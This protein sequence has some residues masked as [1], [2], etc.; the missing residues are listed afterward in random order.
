[1]DISNKW[2]TRERPS[3][4][5]FR[6]TGSCHCGPEAK[7]R[8][9]PFHRDGTSVLGSYQRANQVLGTVSTGV[10]TKP[11]DTM[12][13]PESWMQMQF[14]SPDLKGNLKIQTQRRT[15]S[16]NV[17]TRVFLAQFWNS[18]PSCC[19][20][21]CDSPLRVFLG[22]MS[23]ILSEPEQGDGSHHSKRHLPPVRR[24]RLNAAVQ[25]F[26]KCR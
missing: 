25:T 19:C 26:V 1:M 9:Q 5:T 2:C 3:N 4:F 16:R 20:M 8:W 23:W 22:H 10:K 6:K 7:S 24:T 21:H 11:D 17:S 18:S 15:R 14:W 13:L 12:T